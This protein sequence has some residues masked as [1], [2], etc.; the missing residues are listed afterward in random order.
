MNP[1]GVK[2]AKRHLFVLLLVVGFLGLDQ[3]I[4]W[5]FQNLTIAVLKSDVR[6]KELFF[7]KI[8]LQAKK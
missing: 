2:T 8:F 6:S 3:L 1:N 4:G 7:K 5:S